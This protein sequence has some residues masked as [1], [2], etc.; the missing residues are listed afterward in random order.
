[1]NDPR[2]SNRSSHVQDLVEG[3]GHKATWTELGV[4][5]CHDQAA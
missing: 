2:Q 1:M 5:W 3:E 4:L